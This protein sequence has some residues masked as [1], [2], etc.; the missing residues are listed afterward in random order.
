LDRISEET[1]REMLEMGNNITDKVQKRQLIRC[2][3][4]NRME[5]RKRQKKV[6][7]WVP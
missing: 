2:G 6:R 7:N 3:H 4:T 5:K 1:T